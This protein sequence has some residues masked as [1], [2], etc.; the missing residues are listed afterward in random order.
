MIRWHRGLHWE[1]PTRCS[2]RIA[3]VCSDNAHQRLVM[4]NLALYDTFE[5]NK[6][7]SFYYSFLLLPKQKREAI[8]VVYAWCRLTDDI[9]DE[10]ESVNLKQ[11]CLRQW[12]YEFE[13][14]M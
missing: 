14:A 11:V 10:E 8:N 6:R 5:K 9:V 3:R 13:Q 2:L 4:E 1:W 7:S 12:T